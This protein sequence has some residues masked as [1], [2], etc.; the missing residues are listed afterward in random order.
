MAEGGA[1]G[2]AAAALVDFTPEALLLCGALGFVGGNTGIAV[3]RDVLAGSRGVKLVSKYGQA[4]LD[5]CSVY[6]KGAHR[7]AAFWDAL[8]ALCITKWEVVEM[9]QEKMSS[10]GSYTAYR[11]S[12]RGRAL[13]WRGRWLWRH[14]HSWCWLCGWPCIGTDGRGAL[15]SRLWS[16]SCRC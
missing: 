4:R 15:R 9:R 12:A 16:P 6:G 10:G 5:G 2:G 11:L 7:S 3:V 14:W 8:L 13:L 1:G